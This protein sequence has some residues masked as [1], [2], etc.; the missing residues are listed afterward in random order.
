M[1][2]AIVVSVNVAVLAPAATVTLAGVVADALSSE[3]VTR[4][5]PV[6]AG[7][8]KVTVPVEELPPVTD[9]GFM[10]TEE[11]AAGFTVNEV[12]FATP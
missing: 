8:V 12:V 7:P 5:P 3:S 4:I 1:P 10:L 9:A 6:G 11:R 2:T